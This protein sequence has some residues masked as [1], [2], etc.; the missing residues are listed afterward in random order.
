MYILSTSLST[1][2]EKIRNAIRKSELYHYI[3]GINHTSVV[4]KELK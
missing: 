4:N 3:T 1:M 2:S